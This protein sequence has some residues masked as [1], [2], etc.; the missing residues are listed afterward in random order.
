M[1]LTMI[2]CTFVA[3]LPDNLYLL[4]QIFVECK[5]CDCQGSPENNENQPPTKNYY[6]VFMGYSTVVTRYCAAHLQSYSTATCKLKAN[7]LTMTPLFQCRPCRLCLCMLHTLD[8]TSSGNQWDS[9]IVTELSRCPGLLT[10]RGYSLLLKSMR[11]WFICIKSNR[12][13]SPLQ[14]KLCSNKEDQCHNHGIM[15]LNMHQLTVSSH[16]QRNS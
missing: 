9:V 15:W 4:W 7:T 8:T 2:M 1:C 3:T 6:L 16:T 10:Q 11:Q 12:V 5:F 14:Y 13:C